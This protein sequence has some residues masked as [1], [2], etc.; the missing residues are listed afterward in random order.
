[1]NLNYIGIGIKT[2]F[3]AIGTWLSIRLGT[4]YPVMWVLFAVMALDFVTAWARAIVTGEKLQSRKCSKGIAKKVL[5]LVGV[6]VGLVLDYLLS[7]A[8]L[9]VDIA[10]ST[11]F[12]LL[13]AIWLILN[14]LVSI[15][16]NIGQAGVNM[17]AGISKAVKL[18][19]NYVDK[20]D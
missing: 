2:M 4:L 20:E 6:G 16:E 1:M 10:A 17:P 18:L 5:Y 3:A 19:Q 9:Q 14:D 8:L 15:L 13:V 7:L 11:P 12:G